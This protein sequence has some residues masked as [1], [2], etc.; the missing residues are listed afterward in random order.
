MIDAGICMHHAFYACDVD[1]CGRVHA[2]VAAH[3]S[4]ANQAALLSFACYAGSRCM[5]VIGGQLGCSLLE[6]VH[7]SFMAF[8]II[9]LHMNFS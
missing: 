9:K 1:A 5:V 2:Q 4:L 3:F 8:V 6:P 7:L